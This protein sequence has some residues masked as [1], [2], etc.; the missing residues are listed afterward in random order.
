MNTKELGLEKINELVIRFNEQIVS[1]KK[2]EYNETQIT[3]LENKVNDLVYKI[4]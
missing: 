4:V 3:Y 1:Y 2:S